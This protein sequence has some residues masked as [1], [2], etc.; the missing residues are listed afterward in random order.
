MRTVFPFSYLFIGD[1][2]KL[3]PI[4]EIREFLEKYATELGLTIF[5]IEVKKGSNPQITVFV[6]KDGGID[7]DS[8]E[9]FHKAI[10]EPLDELDPTFGEPYILNVSSPGADRPFKTEQ[11][12]LSHVGKMVEVKVKQSIKGKK[13]FDGVLV[14]YDTK[15]VVVKID[16]KTTLTIDMK[17]LSKMSEYIDF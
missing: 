1:K 9:K 12:F 16:A 13:S 7:L 4:S 15:T 14:S 8:C 17:N 5:D 10:F 2:M 3:K 11:D 6:E